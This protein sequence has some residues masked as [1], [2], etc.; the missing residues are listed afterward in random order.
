LPRYLER[1]PLDK[2]QS[3]LGVATAKVLKVYEDLKRLADAG[4]SVFKAPS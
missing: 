3:R 1:L 4:E 2:R